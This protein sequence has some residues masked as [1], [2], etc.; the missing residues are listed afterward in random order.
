MVLDAMGLDE[1]AFCS[2]QPSALED[3][4]WTERGGLVGLPVESARTLAP[5]GAVGVDGRSFSFV[6]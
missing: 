5:L 1:L 4:V 3:L 2:V 6:C